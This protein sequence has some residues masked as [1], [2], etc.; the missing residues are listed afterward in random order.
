MRN[1]GLNQDQS[2]GEGGKNYQ[3]GGDIVIHTDLDEMRA[4]ALSVYKENALELR[5]IAEDVAY[6]RADKLTNEFLGKLH[7]NNP[8]S[9][10]ALSDPDMQSVLFDAQTQYARSG[11]DDLGKVLVDLLADR[12][13]Q[14]GRT[15]RTLALNEAITSAPKLTEEQRCVIGLVFILRYA[16]FVGA[17]NAQKLYESFIKP[18]VLP[19]AAHIPDK[20]ADYQHIEYVGAGSISL[21]EIKFGDVIRIGSEGLFTKGFDLEDLPDEWDLTD[22]SQYGIR[23]SIRDFQK[24]Q[25]NAGS[26]QDVEEVAA[27]LGKPAIADQLRKLFEKGIMTGQDVLEELKVLDPDVAEASKKWDDS[28]AK[29]LTLTTVGIAIGHAYWR[30]VT[31]NDAPLSFWL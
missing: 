19:L 16:R 5:G 3:A 4:V 15:L 17:G 29:N 6:A 1:K 7:E 8:D 31:G 10:G 23:R 21:S 18:S 28:A 25:V 26:V 24:W 11:E 13:G 20:Q 2:S 12:A 27:N 30:R 14:E 9:V 22:V